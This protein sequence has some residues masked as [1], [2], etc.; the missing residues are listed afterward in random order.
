M[1]LNYNKFLSNS[2]RSDVIGYNIYTRGLRAE[3]N[4]SERLTDVTDKWDAPEP[5]LSGTIAIGYQIDK[6]DVLCPS[7]RINGNLLELKVIRNYWT[8]AYMTTY[9]RSVPHGEYRKSGLYCIRETK[10]FTA[11]DTFISE[12]TVFND[13]RDIA[14]LEVSLTSPFERSN[15]G[16]YK[17]NAKIMPG[18]LYADISL[19]GYGA[20]FFS[21]GHELCVNLQGN[22][23]YTFRYGFAFSKN[24]AQESKTRLSS[25]LKI[26]NAHIEAEKRFN[27]WVDDNAPILETDDIDI[28]K[29]YYYRLFLIKH[30]LHTPSQVLDDAVFNG[31]CAYESPFG[32]WFGAPVGLP[33]PMQIEEMKWLR[34]GGAE[35]QIKAWLTGKGSTHGYI[36]FTPHAVWKYCELSGN[37]NMIAEAYETCKAYTLKGI[38]E[39]GSLPITRGSWVTGAEYQPSFYQHTSPSWDFRHDSDFEDEGFEKSRLHRLDEIVMLALNAK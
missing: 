23:S 10:C 18:S 15:D 9:Y 12:V 11:D 39:D 8:P 4:T 16:T 21:E 31:E 1:K 37:D 36:Q 17:V 32:K 30:S 20:A 33:I 27:K 3:N 6:S 24:S 13:D 34:C 2:K 22:E 26:N 29:V 25:A 7:F 35:N 19:N 28:L 14:E 5:G 38:G